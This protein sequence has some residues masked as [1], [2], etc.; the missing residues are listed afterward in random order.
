[1]ATAPKVQT[2]AQA[3]AE[4]N[5]AY[6]ASKNIVAQRQSGVGAKYDAQ[7]ASI[8]AERGQGFNAINNQATARGGSF[9]GIAQ[10]EQAMYLSTKY[11]PGMQQADYQENQEG[12]TYAQQLADMDKE[13]RTGA[14]GRVDQQKS[15]LNSW[16]MQEA[17]LQAQAKEAALDRQF[18]ASQNAIKNAQ[19]APKAMTAYEAALAQIN[20]AV[21]AGRKI[22]AN[23]FQTARDAYKV[24]GG[25]KGQFA[26]EFWK[27]VPK[28]A[29]KSGAWK[30]YYYG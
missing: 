29:T 3:M 6:A 12:L 13:L 16:N 25:D 24:A 7:R 5:P 8:N 18:Q 4:L 21:A 10:D 11:L 27:Y 9:A 15:Q 19:S 28:E 14:L 2:L 23:V 1:M 30:D 22:D 17:Q 26:S 20:S